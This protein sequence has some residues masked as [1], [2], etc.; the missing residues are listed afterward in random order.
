MDLNKDE[1]ETT[2]LGDENMRRT[3][4]SLDFEINPITLSS[5]QDKV[6]QITT[7]T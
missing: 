3:Q 6:T 7:F 4:R 1:D 2:K 5:D